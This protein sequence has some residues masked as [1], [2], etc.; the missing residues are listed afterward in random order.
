[1]IFNHCPGL[2]AKEEDF[3]AAAMLD[4]EGDPSDSREE[5]AYRMWVNSLNLDRNV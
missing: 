5:R 3:K 1:L 4:E 2:T